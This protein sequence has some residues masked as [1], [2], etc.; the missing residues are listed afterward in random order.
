[1]PNPFVYPLTPTKRKHGPSG[2]KNYESYRDWLRD[3]FTF[4]CVFCLRRELWGIVRASFHIDHFIPQCRDSLGKLD[5]DNLLYVCSS[6]N[7]SKSSH[8]VCD[9]CEVALGN[10]VLIREDGTITALNED[11]ELLIDCLRL[12]NEDYTQFRYLIIGIIRSCIKHNDKER[13][14]LM[15]G[16]PKSLPDISKLKPPGGNKRPEGIHYS[17]YARRSRG[18][19][20][21]LW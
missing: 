6:C 5:Y 14:L 16:Y 21:E 3:D 8:I 1:M 11:G 13:L 2:Y 20:S 12:D 17:F 4:R 7:A 18:E 9:P 15:L 10:C 19:L